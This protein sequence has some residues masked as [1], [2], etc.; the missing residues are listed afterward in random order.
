MALKAGPHI[1]SSNSLNG[2]ESSK[3]IYYLQNHGS[4][5]LLARI[6]YQLNIES[7]YSLSRVDYQLNHGSEYSIARIYSQPNLRLGRARSLERTQISSHGYWL[8]LLC[9]ASGGPQSP[10]SLP[11]C[12]LNGP[13]KQQA[14]TLSGSSLNSLERSKRI[15][16]QDV[17]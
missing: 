9:C 12:S 8:F 5:Y 17:H 10:P 14:Y 1:T 13:E 2:L 7:E 6:D 16:Y 11:G 4:E 15:H 3:R